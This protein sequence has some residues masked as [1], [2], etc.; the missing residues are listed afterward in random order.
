MDKITCIAYLL[1][2]SSTNQDIRE[3]AIQLLNG[4]VSIRDLKRNISIQANLVIAESFLKKNKIDKDQVQQF[5]EQF[6]YQEI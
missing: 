6:M 1:Y 4:D 2:K 3:K 5:A